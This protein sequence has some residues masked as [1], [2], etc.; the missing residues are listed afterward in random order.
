MYKI[1][2]DYDYVLRV[3]SR[4]DFVI[5][6]LPRV[7]TTM[8]ADGASNRNFN[9]FKVKLREDILAARQLNTF[10]PLT[11]LFKKIRKLPQLLRKE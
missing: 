5:E 10:A 6:Y 1:S 7:I 8:K 9:S 11:V 2:G 4:H 3:F